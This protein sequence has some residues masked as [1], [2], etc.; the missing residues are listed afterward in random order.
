MA[1]SVARGVG[2]G[3]TSIGVLVEAGSVAADVVDDSNDDSVDAT[4]DGLG[5]EEAS[6]LAT[7][8]VATPRSHSV[9]TKPGGQM[10]TNP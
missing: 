8:V 4:C 5:V 6:L 2:V 7:G 10:Q 3:V 1:G 9:P